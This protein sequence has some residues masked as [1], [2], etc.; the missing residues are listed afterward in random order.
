MRL[1]NKELLLASFIVI[2]A[3]SWFFPLL[4]FF[5]NTV[6]SVETRYQELLLIFGF[7]YLGIL[8]FAII[9]TTFMKKRFSRDLLLSLW[10]LLGSISSA[11]IFLLKNG[12]PFQ[13][14]LISLMVGA[15]LGLGFPSCLA[16][17]SDRVSLE[18]RG[19]ISGI[20]MFF[21]FIGIF[22]IGAII[23]ILN[24]TE[25]VLVFTL[26]RMIGLIIF[27]KFN[28]KKAEIDEGVDVK[29]KLLLL[30]RPLLFYIIPWIMFSL[31]NFFGYPLQQNY[32]GI[33]TSTLIAMAEFGIGSIAALIAGYFSDVFG[34]KRITIAGYVI[35]GVGYAILGILP[36]NNI[37]L[38]LYIFF[39]AIAWGVLAAIFFIIIW[40]DLAK[41][42]KKDKYFLLG[43]LPFLLS[44]YISIIIDPYVEIIPISTSFSVTSFF[45]FL[46]VLPLLYAPET[47]SEKTM[48][49]KELKKYIKKAKEMKR[50]KE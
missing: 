13:I 43:A 41:N 39:D 48:K 36:T 4:I 40:G 22:L 29:F 31:V 33:E 14:Y 15:S 1:N 24:F 47:L 26:W 7:H 38:G 18:R 27:L 5:T 37:S 6:Y 10:M 44:S 17:F 45:L 35:L 28:S 49:E 16:Y 21:A 32:W 46:A 42:R 25:G 8:I 30:E 23:S 34:R 19:R 3:F 9:G 20:V 2:N 12:N 11:S 50:R